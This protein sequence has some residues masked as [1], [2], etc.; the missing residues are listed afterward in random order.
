M[1]KSAT[2]HLASEH[3]L[4]R[5]YMDAV[6][7]FASALAEPAGDVPPV[8]LR[9]LWPALDYLV[10]VLL[11]RHEEKEE[12]VLLPALQQLGLPWADGSLAHVRRE[13]RQG[14]YLVAALRQAV[15]QRAPWTREDRR[16][17][18]ALALE[19]V[20]FTRRHMEQEEQI[21]FPFLAERASADL[22]DALQ[23]RFVAIDREVDELPN[24]ARLAEAGQRFSS[25]AP[26]SRCE[27]EA[28][29]RAR[30]PIRAQVLPGEA[31]LD[32][33]LVARLARAEKHAGC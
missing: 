29:N 14:R 17:F 1:L 19:W 6:E 25:R 11:L 8:D 33:A 18:V 10:D 21:L 5:R 12:T 3:D 30:E 9:R 27:G 2:H 26:A 22:D 13:H 23:A 31:G 16:H 15:H 20:A 24:A 28:A 7:S 4:I 32:S